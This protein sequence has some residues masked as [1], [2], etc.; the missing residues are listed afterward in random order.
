[1]TGIGSEQFSPERLA[2]RA[3]IQDLIARY[4]RAVDRLDLDGIRAAYHPDAVDD[5][6]GYAGNV[7]GF[8]EYVRDRHAKIPFSM[9]SVSNSVIEFTGAD[10][11][12]VETY[13]TTFQYYPPEAREALAVLA[14]DRISGTGTAYYLL[15]GRYLDEVTRRDGQ[16]RF[17][18]RRGVYDAGV[19]FEG[20]AAATGPTFTT[21]TR[22]KQDPVYQTLAAMLAG[23]T[24]L[25]ANA[26]R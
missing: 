12:H 17:Q 11:A 15:A 7:D 25:G 19:V 1:M 8:V 21:G 16:W 13:V 10:V 4:C 24:L 9:H 22:D 26:G 23:G 14:G 6:G 2:D 5:H 20:Q 3:Q 18:N